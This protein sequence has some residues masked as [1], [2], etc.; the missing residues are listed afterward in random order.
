LQE[1]EK[2]MLRHQFRVTFGLTS[3]FKR[4]ATG[5]PGNA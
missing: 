1:S 3:S 2:A 5:V 4:L